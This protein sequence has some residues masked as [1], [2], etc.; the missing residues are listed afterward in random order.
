MTENAF[1]VCYVV[2]YRDPDYV[3]T[4]TLRAAILRVVNCELI[5]ATSQK[6][7]LLRYID[8]AWK[9]LKAR[10]HDHPDIYILGFRGHEIFWLIRLITIGKP[11]IFDEFMSPTDALLSE[12]KAGNVGR[13]AGA[14]TYPLEWLCLRLSSRCLTDTMLHKEFIARR[15]GV[16]KSRIDVVYVGASDVGVAPP[17]PVDGEK[18]LSVLFY[19]TFLP[20]HGV[21]VILRA[22]QIVADKPIEFH[23]IGGKGKSLT[24]FRK[25]LDELAPGNVEHHAWVDFSELQKNIIPHADLCLGGPFGGTPQARRVITGKTFQFLAQGKPTVVGR[26][27]EPTGFVDR[28]NCLLV[29]QADPESLG[30][31]IE[32]AF[33]NRHRLSDIGKSGRKLFEERYSNEALARQ[34]EP[35]LRAVL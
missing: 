3:R 27:D 11:L 1:K 20:L 32:W 4:R 23:L 18:P 19:G 34:L 24:E 28:Q 35:A 8:S 5:D 22:C 13:I 21:D 6:R 9:T 10:I 31:A 7:G 30:A 33:E 12:G 14:I 2:A 26:I 17:T 29:N 25:L 16:P 15:F